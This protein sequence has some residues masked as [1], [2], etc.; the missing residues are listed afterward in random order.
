MFQLVSP[1]SKVLVLTLSVG[2]T[3][4]TL[5]TMTEA[6]QHDADPAQQAVHLPLVVVVGHRSD[7]SVPAEAV[8]DVRQLPD[9]AKLTKMS[10]PSKETAI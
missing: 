6:F 2:L 10:T 9:G 8:A 5:S 7:L 1:L 4:S 3:W